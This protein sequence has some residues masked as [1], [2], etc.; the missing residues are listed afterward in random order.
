V[1]C[2]DIGDK[3]RYKE[4]AEARDTI[5]LGPAHYFVLERLK[6]TDTR[7]PNNACTLFVEGIKVEGSILDSFGC[8]YEC[9]L[10]ETVIFASLFAIEVVGPIVI[11][12][13]ASDARLEFFGIKKSDFSGTRNSLFEI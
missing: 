10:T 12:Y 3:V 1:S 4:W 7:A 9:K 8:R 11:F 2:S 5:S 6:T 13:L